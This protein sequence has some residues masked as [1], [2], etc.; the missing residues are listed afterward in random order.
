[1]IGLPRALELMMG[2]QTIKADEAQRIGLVNATFPDETFREEVAKRA[3]DLANNVSPRSASIIKRMTYAACTSSLAQA[4]HAV[5][6]EIP[7]VLASEDF[8]EGV[9]HFLEKRPAQFT[10]N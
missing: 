5:D 4:V 3:H 8:R 7:G 2:G 1:M 6:D 10:G 9:A